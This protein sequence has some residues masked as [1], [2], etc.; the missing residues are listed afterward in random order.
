MARHNNIPIG[1]ASRPLSTV[2][3]VVVSPDMDSKKA[4]MKEMGRLEKANGRA[5]NVASA[6][7]LTEVRTNVCRSESLVLRCGR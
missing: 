6:I 1:A 5:P 3:P 2:D 7:Q 4:S